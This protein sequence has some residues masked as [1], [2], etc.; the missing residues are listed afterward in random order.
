MGRRSTGT[1]EAR[2]ESIRLKF[3]YL[4]ERQVEILDLA[5]TP[6]NLK[7][8]H[9]LMANIIKAIEAG[10]YSR[11]D[12]FQTTG[13]SSNETFQDYV[14]EWAKTL[15][16]AKSTKRSYMTAMNA[17]WI[18]AFGT[19]K[20]RSVVFSDVK[21]AIADKLKAGASGKTINNHV[22]PLRDLFE[23]ARKDGL[24]QTNPTEGI[25]N[26]PHQ[27]QEP[28]P[29]TAPERD[30]LLDH[31][32][33]KYPDQV[34]DYFRF[35]FATGM[36][37]SEIIALTW[38]DV[39]FNKRVVRVSKAMVDWEAKDTKTNRIRDVDLSTDAMAALNRQKTRSF[40]A[41][42][43][44]FTNPN[45][46]KAWADEQVQRRR[47]WNP[48]LKALGMRQR[49]AYQTRH[50]YASLLLMGGINPA[51]IA[52][53]LGHSQITTTLRVYACWIEGADNGSERAKAEAILSRNCPRKTGTP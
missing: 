35:A 10:V 38:G 37:P 12:F 52:K 8:A 25:K 15:T 30:R 24:I 44:I 45:T 43:A 18:P 34:V 17:T 29:F 14:Q 33:Q 13:S 41:D 27:T 48:S 31:M 28:D 6:Q 40:L 2:K 50:T 22:T 42:E 1:V 47:Y 20:L 11:G 32:E 5:P 23:I 53:Q 39:D 16:G 3:T 21:K 49:D 4:G 9:R 26:L 51:Y 7:A 46:S 19:K 36:R